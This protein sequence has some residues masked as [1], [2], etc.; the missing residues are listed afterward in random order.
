MQRLDRAA[1]AIRANLLEVELDENRELLDA[2]MLEGES[3]TRWGKASATLAHLWRWHAQLEQTL[4]RAKK[5]RGTRRHLSAARLAQLEELLRGQSIEL[6]NEQVPLE[7]RNLLSDPDSQQRCT[8]DELLKRMAS[9]FDQAKLVLAG[10]EDAWGALTPR[11]DRARA[12][13]ETNAKLARALGEGEPPQLDYARRRIEKLTNKLYKDP[14][15]VSGEEVQDVERSLQLIRED[16]EGLDRVRGELDVLLADARKLL[17]ELRELA[18]ESRQ[19]NQ[20]VLAKIAAPTVSDPLKLDASFESQLDDVAKM[21]RH[22][23]WREARA[24]LEQWS[25]RAR[26]LLAHG[27]QSLAQNHVPL[28]ERSELRGLLDACQGKARR[29]GLIE[30]PMLSQLFNEAHQRLYTAPTDLVAGRE[31]VERYRQSLADHAPR[32]E[33]LR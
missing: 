12:A 29:L 6:A 13:L 19:A 32:P 22:G 31:L 28:R 14:L 24:V 25:S 16:L 9:A 10:V 8:P 11:L 18:D 5:T 33:L 20:D 27:Q 30:D 7:Q 21:A 17:E 26:S 4:E 23:A 15:S 1:K 3:A 2:A